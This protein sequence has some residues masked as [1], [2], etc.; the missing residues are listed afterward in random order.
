MY[1]FLVHEKQA[2][3]LKEAVGDFIPI[4]LVVFRKAGARYAAIMVK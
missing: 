4:A 1:S 2:Y 3:A